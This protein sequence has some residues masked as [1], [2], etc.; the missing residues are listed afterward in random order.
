MPDVT[1]GPDELCLLGMVTG[2][3]GLRGE[4][5]IRPLSADSDALLQAEEL[6]LRRT[7]ETVCC[8][9]SKV[10]VHKGNLLLRLEGFSDIDA[11]LPFVGCEVLM[12]YGDLPELSDDEFYWFELVGMRVTD[13]TGSE[14]GILEDLFTTAAHDIYVVRG[15]FG[16]ILIPAVDEF[17]VQIDREGKHLLVDLP[18]GMIPESEQ[19]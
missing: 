14:L 1:P 8:K 7:G 10:S 16:E 19:E 13:Q 11:V 6:F 15:P 3:H 9:P 18:Q 4:L 2:T 5:K 12:R 17:I